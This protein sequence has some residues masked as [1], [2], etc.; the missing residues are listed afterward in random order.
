MNNLGQFLRDY[1]REHNERI[2]YEIK[3]GFRTEKF[4][5]ADVYSL[6]LKTDTFLK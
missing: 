3:R 4:R 1:S 6:S 2:A 5:F